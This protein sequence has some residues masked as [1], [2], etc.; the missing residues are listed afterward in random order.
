[1]KSI[2]ICLSNEGSCFGVKPALRPPLWRRKLTLLWLGYWTV[3]CGVFRCNCKECF[4]NNRHHCGPLNAP[5]VYQLNTEENRQEESDHD[6]PPGPE[7][8]GTDECSLNSSTA[9]YPALISL[10]P[11]APPGQAWENEKWP[12]V[13]TSIRYKYPGQPEVRVQTEWSMSDY[14]ERSTHYTRVFR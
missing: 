13:A 9:P 8:A 7:Y 11:A 2:E 5:S 6:E 3:D 4:S 1:M 10:Y 14:G 12:G